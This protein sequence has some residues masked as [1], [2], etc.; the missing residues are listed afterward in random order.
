MEALGGLSH[1]R[2]LCVVRCLALSDILLM[3]L[4]K[5]FKNQ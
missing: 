4:Y 5:K 2:F 1:G 3:D